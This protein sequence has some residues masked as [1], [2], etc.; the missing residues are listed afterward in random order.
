MLERQTK[1]IVSLL[2]NYAKVPQSPDY[3]VELWK[4]L[5][6]LSVQSY[7]TVLPSRFSAPSHDAQRVYLFVNVYEQLT[8]P[9]T[10]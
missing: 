7:R 8:K 2:E 9:T 4:A 3:R 1:N 10:D 5:N 6:V